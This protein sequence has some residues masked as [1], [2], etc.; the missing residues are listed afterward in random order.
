[1]FVILVEHHE[2]WNMKVSN[3]LPTPWGA[4]MWVPNYQK[5]LEP[6]ACWS[7]GMRLWRSH[8]LH[9]FTRTCTKPT[10]SGQCIVGTLLVLRR[11]TGNSD[12]QNSPQLGLR[13]S[14][15]LP[16]YNILCTSPWGPH[17]NGFLSQDSQVGVPK[18]PDAPPSSL[19]DPKWVPRCWRAEV[20]KTWCRSQLSAL[21]G[22][23]GRAE[24]PGLD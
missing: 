11:A 24:A 17:P 23:E 6:G 9:S 7:F 10:Q 2:W 5:C 1:M 18:F 21:E 15:H 13:G 22:V 3:A 20:V 8:K 4:Q 16:P 19:L 12:T 14:H